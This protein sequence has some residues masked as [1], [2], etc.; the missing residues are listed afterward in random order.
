MNPAI[1]TAKGKIGD[2]SRGRSGMNPEPRPHKYD[3][4]LSPKD[5]L[6]AVMRDPTVPLELRID[7]AGKA[8]SVHLPDPDLRDSGVTYRIPELPLQ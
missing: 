3:R 7:A 1:E 5:F 2:D 4:Q 6:L 8:L